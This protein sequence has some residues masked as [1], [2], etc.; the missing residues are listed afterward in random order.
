MNVFLS[1]RLHRISNYVKHDEF[2]FDCQSAGVFGPV[3][4]RNERTEVGGSGEDESID[5]VFLEVLD[6]FVFLEEGG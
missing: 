1:E 6:P 2:G 3:A 5:V 4:V